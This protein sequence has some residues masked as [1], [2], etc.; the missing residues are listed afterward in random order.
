[1]APVESYWT[2]ILI[3]ICSTSTKVYWPNVDSLWRVTFIYLNLK[4]LFS[5]W[6]STYHLVF[7]RR[8]KT[9]APFRCFTFD[10]HNLWLDFL[11]VG[12]FRMAST[13]LTSFSSRHQRFLSLARSPG[14]RIF[15]LD[16]SLCDHSHSC[17]ST[18]DSIGLDHF[19]NKVQW[20]KQ[21]TIAIELTVSLIFLIFQWIQTVWKI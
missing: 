18:L 1:M 8:K 17:R 21:M 9:F 5:H 7:Y 13:I 2:F 14:K 15:R 19:C 3:E 6:W 16:S 11:L 4:I 12:Y 20:E 10:Y